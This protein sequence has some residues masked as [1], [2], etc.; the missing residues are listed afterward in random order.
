M[1]ACLQSLVFIVNF[2]KFPFLHQIPLYAC[3]NPVFIHTY[4]NYLTSINICESTAHDFNH[5]CLRRQLSLKCG[6]NF[7][8]QKFLLSRFHSKQGIGF[9]IRVFLQPKNP[10]YEVL[11]TE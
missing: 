8:F 10:F 5:Y 9:Q 6:S 1:H 2:T 11:F 7:S 4:Q 3:S